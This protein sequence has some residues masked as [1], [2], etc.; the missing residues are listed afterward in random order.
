MGCAEQEFRTNKRGNNIF[1]SIRFGIL[2]DNGESGENVHLI[3]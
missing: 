1:V 3:I 2:K